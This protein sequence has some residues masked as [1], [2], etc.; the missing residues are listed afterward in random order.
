MT[1][2]YILAYLS[3]SVATVLLWSRL[4]RIF[5]KKP[6]WIFS[7]VLS[8][9]AF[10]GMYFGGRGD[11]QWILALSAL[12]GAGGGCGAVVA[13]SI[14]SDVIDWDE[15]RTG[16]RKEGTY[17]AAWSFVFKGSVGLTLLLTGSVLQATGFVPN[18]EQTPT[19]EAAIRA[20]FSLLPLCTYLIGALLLSR[21]RLDRRAH[22]A[23]RAELDRRQMARSD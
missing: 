17:F 7:M 22:R 11:W 19:S 12:G 1:P 14:Q 8:G 15:H 23:I 3:A 16:E 2:L 18:V 21:F 10:G 4:A 5:D 13:P 6:L 9:A 20:L